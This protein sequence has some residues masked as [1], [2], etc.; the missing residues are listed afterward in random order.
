MT[1]FLKITWRNVW[2][3]WR[4]TVIALAA[5][6]LG[7]FF[8]V[9]MDGVM[10]GS[11][12]AIYGNL[13]KVL[14]GNIQVHA[15]GYGEKAGRSPLLPIPNPDQVLQAAL[16]RPEV[17]GASSRI[18]TGGFATSRDASLPV[19]ISGIEP[20]KEAPLS[21]IADHIIEG[22]YLTAED[23]DAI[24]IGYTL[25]ERLNIGLNDR[26]SLVGRAPHEQM[27]T[28]T[29]TVVGIYR[30]GSPETEKRN[31]YM[32]LA[33][34]QS[35]YDLPGQVTEIVVALNSVGNEEPT[36]S[37]LRSSLSGVEVDSWKDLNP[38]LLNAYALGDKIM[39]IFG[40]IVLGIAGI[41]IL[42]LMLMAVF[43]RTREIGLLSAIGLKRRQILLLF[44]MEGTLIGVLGGVV[45]AVLGAVVVTIA[46]SIGFDLSM[47]AEASEMMG[48][49]GTYLYPV[50]EAGPLVSRFITVIFISALASL[51]PAWQA[52]NSQP[53]EALH[54]V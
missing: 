26:I 16:A 15:Q 40:F 25:A 48:L 21:L 31:V 33:E 35:L 1:K 22:R 29:M 42:N 32:S 27:R 52:A 14:G 45:G 23:Q 39:G 47:A 18:Q 5:I 2:R 19:A 3:N 37:A 13:I 49:L 54:Y 51:Y 50:L 8:L 46:G 41:G 17:T 36:V 12:V 11:R 30:I 28:R 38:A 6:S 53:A 44:L 24:L 10:S 20:E 43:E 34:A 9:F 7:L 4:R